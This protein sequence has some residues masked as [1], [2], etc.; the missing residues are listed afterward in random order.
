MEIKVWRQKYGDKS[1]EIHNF[2]KQKKEN[3]VLILLFIGSE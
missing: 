3:I 2:K 1:M